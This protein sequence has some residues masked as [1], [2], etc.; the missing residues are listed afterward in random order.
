MIFDLIPDSDPRLHTRVADFDFTNPPVDPVSFYADML[1]T[2]RANRGAGLA[3]N[4]CGLPYRAFTAYDGEE[5][6][7]A[8]N[9]RIEFHSEEAVSEKEGCLSFPGMILEVA[10]HRHVRL[11]GQD[12][13][14]VWFTRLLSNFQA[15]AAQHELDHLN[16]I[17]FVTRANEN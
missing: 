14:G 2:M 9:P 15:R 11:R 10:R 13:N 8:F 1:E 3:A 12:E 17:T 16:G 5:P 4:Q 6:Y 7:I